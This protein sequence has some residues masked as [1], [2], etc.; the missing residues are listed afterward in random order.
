MKTIL[1]DNL[2]HINS[3]SILKFFT[4]TILRELRI[5]NI[6]LDH[7]VYEKLRDFLSFNLFNEKVNI[8]NI[9]VLR[10]L[11][12]PDVTQIIINTFKNEINKLTLI[13]LE[14]KD[15]FKSKYIPNIGINKNLIK[16][17]ES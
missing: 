2:N 11:S 4:A 17:I 6:G 8:E 14:M 12:E 16:I 15:L 1:F 5:T 9:D 3:I 13:N 10:N 7:F